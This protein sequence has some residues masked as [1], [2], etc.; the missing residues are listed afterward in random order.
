[1]ADALGASTPRGSTADGR[2]GDDLE[3][4][5]GGTTLKRK[6]GEEVQQQVR[7]RRT[8]AFSPGAQAAIQEDGGRMV[9]R[10]EL[11]QMSS[12]VAPAGGVVHRP[13]VHRWRDESPAPDAKSGDKFWDDAKQVGA[14][15]AGGVARVGKALGASGFMLIAMIL[16]SYVTMELSKSAVTIT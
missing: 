14:R 2:A 10:L 4:A 8:P 15:G 7:R 9:A 11:E 3:A 16:T 5:R 6:G 12:A 1:M 13:I